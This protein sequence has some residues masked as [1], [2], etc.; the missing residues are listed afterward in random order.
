MPDPYNEFQASRGYTLSETQFGKICTHTQTYAQLVFFDGINDR[1]RITR[2][3]F[4]QLNLLSANDPM[5][6]L[7]L[8]PILPPFCPP[9]LLPSG[10]I[11]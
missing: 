8:P 11:K 2:S 7:T 10:H 5:G 9:R 1:H 3:E 6:Q 4:K